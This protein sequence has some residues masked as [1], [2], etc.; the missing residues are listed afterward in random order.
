M[1]NINYRG[2]YFSDVS[3]VISPNGMYIHMY[4]KWGEQP[5][6]T[7]ALFHLH[8]IFVTFPFWLNSSI[9]SVCSCRHKWRTCPLACKR[10]HTHDPAN[11]RALTAWGSHWKRHLRCS[12]SLRFFSTSTVMALMSQGPIYAV[13]NRSHA[14][15]QVNIYL[16]RLF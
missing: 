14:E 10:W 5:S 9:L 2:H 1:P 8:D 3:S 12:F 16:E 13:R 4:T 15:K 7:L 11:A 6:Q